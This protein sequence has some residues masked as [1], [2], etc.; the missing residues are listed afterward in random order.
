MKSPETIPAAFEPRVGNVFALVAVVCCPVTT[1]DCVL[2][3]LVAYVVVAWNTAFTLVV[4]GAKVRRSVAVPLLVTLRSF[5]PHRGVYAIPDHPP[6]ALSGKPGSPLIQLSLV[7]EIVQGGAQRKFAAIGGHLGPLRV[8]GNGGSAPAAI[9]QA[10]VQLERRCAVRACSDR[11]SQDR[12]VAGHFGWQLVGIALG[13]VLLSSVWH[14]L[15]QVGV[16]TVGDVHR[17]S[18]V[19]LVSRFGPPAEATGPHRLDIGSVVRL[20]ERYRKRRV[21]GIYLKIGDLVPSHSEAFPVLIYVIVLLCHIF[22]KKQ[23]NRIS[24]SVL[25]G[26]NQI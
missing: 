11:R 5:V 9:G 19:P 15:A 4:P 21:A 3:E 24:A 6:V 26:T 17:D 2:D 10:E 14:A 25:P 7:P 8:S 22:I 18:F 23:E 16:P 13:C 12:A 1:T 20:G